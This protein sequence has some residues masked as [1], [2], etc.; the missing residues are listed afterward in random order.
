MENR[1]QLLVSI[2]QALFAL[3]KSQDACGITQ[4]LSQYNAFYSMTNMPYLSGLGPNDTTTY[5]GTYC[6]IGGVNANGT[7]FTI[8]GIYVWKEFGI[9]KHEA[10]VQ[11]WDR[12][13]VY[14]SFIACDQS[15]DIGKTLTERQAAWSSTLDGPPWYSMPEPTRPNDKPFPPTWSANASGVWSDYQ[16]GFWCSSQCSTY[17]NNRI[18]IINPMFISQ[19]IAGGA[20]QSSADWP[21]MLVFDMNDDAPRWLNESEFESV[22]P[23]NF[24]AAG[25]NGTGPYDILELE[26]EGCTTHNGT[27]ILH[28]NWAQN[29]LDPYKILY[30][31]YSTTYA[32]DPINDEWTV[33]TGNP[34]DKFQFSCSSDVSGR[35]VYLIAG[36]F[37][38]KSPYGTDVNVDSF[39]TDQY[40]TWTDS[41][42]RLPSTADYPEQYGRFN[43]YSVLDRST[44]SIVVIGGNVWMSPC[45]AN[46]WVSPKKVEVFRCDTLDWYVPSDPMDQI[47]FESSPKTASVVIVHD[48]VPPGQTSNK[49]ADIIFALGGWG[50]NKIQYMTML[51]EQE[52]YPDNIVRIEGQYPEDDA[53]EFTAFDPWQRFELAFRIVITDG[54]SYEIDDTWDISFSI[55]GR[56]IADINDEYATQILARPACQCGRNEVMRCE[57]MPD[58]VIQ[59]TTVELMIPSRRPLHNGYCVD[60]DL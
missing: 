41:W 15:V 29:R 36:K 8:G 11:W 18:Y 59:V 30:D 46:C 42:T 51:T 48:F 1:F 23:N 34:L 12:I 31:P 7:I 2:I 35:Y 58:N 50:E 13:N 27:H 49:S 24:W 54:I 6:Q 19:F 53:I 9:I 52:Y 60:R 22:L 43:A 16:G 55:D 57:N 25:K 17:L 47:H 33:L 37:V 5:R 3:S 20:P 56:S 10:P 44:N 14:D 32:Y 28:F 38:Y 4:T 39:E 26:P 21:L 45:T 40:D